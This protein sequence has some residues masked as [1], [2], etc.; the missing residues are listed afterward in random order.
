MMKKRSHDKNIIYT[1][2]TLSP[3]TSISIITS[4]QKVSA[5]PHSQNHYDA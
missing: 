3:Q 4:N 2:P 1:I 5:I